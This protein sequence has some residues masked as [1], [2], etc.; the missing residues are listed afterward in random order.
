MNQSTNETRCHQIKRLIRRNG[1]EKFFREDGWTENP[2][3]AKTY[4]DV[5][6]AARICVQHGLVDV[7]LTL[8]IEVG[9]CDL[10]STRIC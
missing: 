6:E 2:E 3:E 8:R 5:V 10:F 1:S 7:E 4:P 9:G